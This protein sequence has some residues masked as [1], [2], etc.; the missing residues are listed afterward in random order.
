MQALESSHSDQHRDDP[1]KGSDQS[2]LNSS[3]P[4]DLG[5]AFAEMV[6]HCSFD[7]PESSSVERAHIGIAEII[8]AVI[9]VGAVLLLIQRLFLS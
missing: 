9:V 5:T 1:S 6:E 8:G 3:R 2:K 4:A 7:L